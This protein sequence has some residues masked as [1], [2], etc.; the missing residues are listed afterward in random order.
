[1][2]AALL[3]TYC[4]ESDI[5]T[6]FSTDGETGRVDDD[7]AG[8][9]SPTGEAYV[10]QFINWATAEV[11]GYLLKQYTPA[12]LATDWQVNYWTTVI[13][14]YRL[15][16]RRA[17]PPP[18]SITDL[19]KEVQANLRDARDGRLT[20]DLGLR[21]SHFPAWSNVRVELMNRLHKVV[22]ERPISDTGGGTS[23]TQPAAARDITADYLFDWK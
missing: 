19:Y 18:G 5:Q 9:I 20:L 1:M 22:V 16:C 14:C 3:Y 11:N 23:A 4:S 2:P 21:F 17:N 12:D 7:A 13:V 15:A 6:L 10:Q 8:V